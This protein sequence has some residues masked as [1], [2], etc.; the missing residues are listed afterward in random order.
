MR[1]RMNSLRTRLLL[2][3][4]VI[5]AAFVVLTALALERAYRERAE[6]A[7]QDKLQGLIYAILGATNSGD[8]ALLKV[9]E[10]ELRDARLIQPDSGLYALIVDEVG[11]VIWQSP[12]LLDSLSVAPAHDA[13]V[14]RFRTIQSDNGNQLYTLSLGVNW[15]FGRKTRRYSFIAAEDSVDLLAQLTR[16]R[17]TLWLWL[18]L[19]AGLLLILQSMVL[20]WGLS[21]VRRLVAEL[22][23]IE[24]GNRAEISGDYPDELQ[25]LKAG[26]NT[27]LRYE[28]QQQTR[29]RHA[30]DDLAHS[31]KTPLAVLTSEAERGDLP[32]GLQ[33]RLREQLGRMNQIVDYQLKRAATAG[34]RHL[35]TPGAGA[36]TCRQNLHGPVK[37]LLRQKYPLRD[38]HSASA[39]SAHGRRRPDGDSR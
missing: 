24:A 26:L 21:P 28:R 9:N 6:Q 38:S 5:L 30:L 20:F 18:A 15:T 3:A 31:L 8:A 37:S 39:G 12:S 34:S 25:P 16:F 23:G 32:G 1:F 11:A 10:N 29:Y 36:A 35:S 7:E 17:Q 27:M 2:A 19:P 22:R 4:S 14:W 13:G 33:T